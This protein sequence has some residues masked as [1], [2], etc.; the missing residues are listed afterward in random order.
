[1]LTSS[2]KSGSFKIETDGKAAALEVKKKIVDTLKLQEDDIYLVQNGR[3]LSEDNF[4]T[5]GILH[6]VF[7]LIGG[8]GGFGSMLRAIG[9]QIEKTTN[10]EACRDLSGRRLRDINEEKRLK[11]WIAQQAERERE[12]AERKRKKL[13]RLHAEPKHNF[14]DVTYE[15]ERSMLTEK[16]SDAV[17]QGFKVASSS[18]SSVVSQKRK[19]T[20]LETS[21][22]KKEESFMNTEFMMLDPDEE[23]LSSSVDSDSSDDED[24]KKNIS[25]EPSVSGSGSS[26]SGSRTGSKIKF[27]KGKHRSGLTNVNLENLLRICV[28]NQPARID[29]IVQESSRAQPSTSQ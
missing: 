29:K 28:A 4:V 1:M 12:A 27:I 6:V 19:A 5:K 2:I 11:N 22:T 17:E 8:K 14:Q 18:G 25:N 15:E 10:R 21:V 3:K 7:R 24:V 9:A 20:C 13:E 23:E 26:N 16:V